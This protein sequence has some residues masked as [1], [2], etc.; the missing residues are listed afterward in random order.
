MADVTG[1]ALLLLWLLAVV[2]ADGFVAVVGCF[3]IFESLL[4][5]LPTPKVGISLRIVWLLLLVFPPPPLLVVAAPWCCCCCC[6]ACAATCIRFCA[7][8]SR[9]TRAAFKMACR[10]KPVAMAAS[11]RSDATDP[12]GDRMADQIALAKACLASCDNTTLG[13]LL[14][15]LVTADGGGGGMVDED[16]D[17]DVTRGACGG[18]E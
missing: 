6:C 18:C 8:R 12:S 5:L 1:A 3:M 11:M 15:L 16:D 9:A 4:L 13:L 17:D 14:L 7:S 10:G 2:T